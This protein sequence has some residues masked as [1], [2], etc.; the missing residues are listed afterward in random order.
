MY[1][2]DGVGTT[3]DYNGFDRFGRMTQ[4][5][6]YDYTSTPTTLDRRNYGYDDAGNR[7]WREDVLA[8]AQ[9]TPVHHDEYYT[10]DGLH[11]LKNMQRG[12][13][14]GNP[15]NGIDSAT[16]N[17]EQVQTL[18]Q[19]GNWAEFK[20]RDTDTGST[21]DLDQDRT[22]NAV[23]EIT[24]VTVWAD[25]AHD[26][27]GN[28]TVS[29][30]SATPGS[31]PTD[32]LQLRYDAWNRL[33]S[34]TTS[35]TPSYTVNYEYDGLGRRIFRDLPNGTSSDVH[36]YYNEQWQL[37]EA[38]A[39]SSSN[40]VE[41]FVWHP[42]YIDALAV[43][44][45]DANSS[46]SQVQQFYLQDANF[47]VT[48]VVNS[49]GGVLE[50]Y[51]YTP[52]GEVTFLDPD[53]SLASSQY[54]SAIGNTHLYTGRERDP[55]TGLQLNRE[56][57]YIPPL[58]RWTS[59]DPDVYADSYNLYEYVR[60]KPTINVDPHGTDC[61]GC[62][63]PGF[64]HANDSACVRACCAQHDKCYD[65]H[66]CTSASWGWN[67]GG[68]IIVGIFGGACTGGSGA[69]IGFWNGG[70]VAGLFSSC[71][72]CNSDVA[73]CIVTCAARPNHMAGKKE[74]YCKRQHR[75]IDIP[76]DFLTLDA[77]KAACCQ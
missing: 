1:Q 31:A 48:A 32:T 8:A 51:D 75:F 15:Y 22:H 18:D 29:P 62:D 36:Y 17:R 67:A 72:K 43:R 55:E 65:D 3:N 21:W 13:L 28:M 77:A 39:G 63:L 26:A 34:A 58:G 73:D 70:H 40:P 19:L 33:V 41:Q 60:S 71:A 6:W 59:R 27:A 52:Y 57:F 53:F 54:S 2:V 44:Y 76:G 35:T 7:K 14:T 24:D 66:G 20:D 42:Y 9:S 11:R 38:R 12:N 68:G 64:L 37:L 46:G 56:R 23:N 4:D 16:R 30:W 50:R 45:Y 61:P 49:S 74:Y 69:V 25:P 47:N 10:Y 5:K